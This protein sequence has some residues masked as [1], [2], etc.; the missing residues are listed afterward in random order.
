MQAAVC[1]A[2]DALVNVFPELADRVRQG[3]YEPFG[4][5]ANC[6]SGTMPVNIDYDCGC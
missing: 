6:I 4:P 1:C 3:D 5:D 2:R